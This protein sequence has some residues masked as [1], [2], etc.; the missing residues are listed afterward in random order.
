M[1]RVEFDRVGKRFADTAAVTDFSLAVEDGE[2]ITVLGP[3]G[4]GKSTLLRLTAGLES[5]TQGT[6]HLAGR[7]I[8]GLPPQQRDVAMVFQNYALYPHMNVRRNIE[9]PLRMRGMARAERRQHAENVASLLELSHLLERRPGQLSGGQRQRVAL[10]R[11]L[12]REPALFLLD[13][14]LSNLDARLRHGVRQ[15]IRN[16]QRQLR[17]T[18][19]YVTHDQT[20]AMTLGDRIVVMDQGRIQQVDSPVAMYE[21]PGNTFVAGFIGTPPMSLLPA[22]YAAGTLRIADQSLPA[23]AA[24]R[25]SLGAG[26]RHLTIGIRPEAFV[27]AGPDSSGLIARLDHATSEILG[28][29]TLVRGTIGATRVTVR[30]LGLARDLPTKVVA[31]PAAFHVFAADSGER[32]GP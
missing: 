30:L 7:R 18:T 29:E 17:V 25:T 4:C 23:P 1:G 15:Y 21:R 32:L 24:L 20:E 14:P 28:S 22:D 27:A 5:L 6:I 26:A 3:S 12:V 19:L 9:F 31:P 11:A 8:D 2:L 16:V 10:A 13:E